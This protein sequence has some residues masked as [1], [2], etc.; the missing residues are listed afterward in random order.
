LKWKEL[1]QPRQWQ[2]GV[3]MK[4]SGS[5]A[6]DGTTTVTGSWATGGT[7]TMMGNTATRHD[8]GDARHNDGDG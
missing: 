1:Y 6:T 8:N 3:R 2:M 4:A 7:T 5:T